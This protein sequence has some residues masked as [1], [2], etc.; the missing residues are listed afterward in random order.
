[1]CELTSLSLPTRKGGRRL[2]PQACGALPVLM[3]APSTTPPSSP[4][5][6]GSEYVG[7]SGKAWMCPPGVW[8]KCIDTVHVLLLYFL[9]NISKWRRRASWSQG[10]QRGKEVTGQ[11]VGTGRG[12]TG[13]QGYL[14]MSVA[15]GGA[16]VKGVPSQ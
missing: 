7:D 16:A 3:E 13:L 6:E 11:S 4:F 14:S 10:C 5:E 12:K 8:G 9:R 2:C 15:P 1:M